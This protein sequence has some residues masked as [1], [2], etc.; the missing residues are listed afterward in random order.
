MSLVPV[1]PPTLT[2][3][4]PTNLPGGDLNIASGPNKSQN[5]F[6]FGTNLIF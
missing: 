6:G 5:S 4:T 3:A 2:F 1:P